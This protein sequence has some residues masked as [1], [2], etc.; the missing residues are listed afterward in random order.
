MKSKSVLPGKL[1]VITVSNS[2]QLIPECNDQK[3]AKQ[4]R[5]L[6][7]KTQHLHTRTHTHTVELINGNTLFEAMQFGNAHAYTQ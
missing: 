5:N 4:T 3:K 2:I 7:I 6:K 1:S